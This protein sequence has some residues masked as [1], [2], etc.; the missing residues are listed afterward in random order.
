MSKTNPCNIYAVSCH[1]CMAIQN[2][3]LGLG[4]GLAWMMKPT[5]GQVHLN[6]STR[7]NK[8]DKIKAITNVRVMCSEKNSKAVKQKNRCN[9]WKLENSGSDTSEPD[10]Y[11]DEEDKEDG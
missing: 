10:V 5:S 7:G 4:L 11:S 1:D 8:V 2:L 3:G 9:I 6:L